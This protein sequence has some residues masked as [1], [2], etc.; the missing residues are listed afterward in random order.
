MIPSENYVSAAVLE[1]NGS[2]QINT[3][4]DIRAED[5]MEAIKPYGYY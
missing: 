2:L 5:I 1:A 4:R 3:L